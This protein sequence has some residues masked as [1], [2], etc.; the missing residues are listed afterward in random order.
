[1][2]KILRG[3][4]NQT[5]PIFNLY[6]TSFY[7]C[8]WYNETCCTIW[9][10]IVNSIKLNHF[11]ICTIWIIKSHSWRHRNY[12][13]LLNI[14]SFLKHLS[15]N[16]VIDCYFLIFTWNNV[17]SIINIKISLPFRLIS[18]KTI[19]SKWLWLTLIKTTLVS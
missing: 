9:S 11:V 17:S 1:M 18:T 2:G 10:S 7:L 14:F 5:K 4:M 6:D 12:K 8:K 19:Q 3:E 16:L 15:V 13:I